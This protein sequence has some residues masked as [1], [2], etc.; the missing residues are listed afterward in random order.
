M[1]IDSFLQAFRQQ[2]HADAVVW[3]GES[4]SYGWMLGR[5]LRNTE[6]LAARADVPSGT[7]VAV[8]G[9]Y[10]PHTLAL[11]LA[12][13]EHGCIVVPISPAFLSKR[14]E[15]YEIAEVQ[16]EMTIG[17]GESI[18][19]Q[20]FPRT[21]AH[22]ILRQLID[23]QHPGMVLFS[24]GSTGRSKAAVHDCLRL[25][26]KFSTPRKA[27]RTIPFMLFDHIG[28]I[29]TVLQ[30]LSSNGAI[31]VVEDRTPEV[32][33]EM[34]EK[35]RVQ[36]IPASPTFLNLLLLSDCQGRYDLSSLETIAYGAEPMPESTLQRLHAAFPN[37]HLAQNYGISEVGVMQTKSESSG[38]VWVKV[39]G[40]G[41][42]F[43]IREGLL[44]IKAASAMLG[45]LN[46]PSPFTDDGWFMTGDMVET[47]GEYMRILGRKSEMINVGGEKVYPAEVEGV[48]ARME[49]VLDVTIT[50][51]PHAIVGAIV[52]ATVLLSTDETTAVFRKRMSEFL[53]DKLPSYKIPRKVVLTDQAMHGSRFKKIRKDF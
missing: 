49:G 47:R 25:I 28:G 42:E 9:D 40:E 3:R 21:V 26:K 8:Y 22:P 18:E 34:I 39:G 11:L 27:K 7:V 10:S 32:V 44:E 14:E 50:S 33:C 31:V 15:F 16:V 36:V 43:R 53:A 48:I 35:H 6:M 17:A 23:E 24:S 46:A 41:Y 30:V 1:H 5:V 4:Y 37:V 19:I 52:K 13:I 45:Y 38:S 29:N 20:A 2:E 12:L 51:E